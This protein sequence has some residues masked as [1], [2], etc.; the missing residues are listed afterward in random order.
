MSIQ[1]RKQRKMRYEAPLHKRRA[2]LRA[3]LGKELREKLKTDKRNALI[4]KGDKVKV[5]TGEKKNHMGKVLSVDYSELKIYVEGVLHKT[6]KGTEKPQ[7]VDPSNV[8]IIDGTFDKD[9]KLA[10]ERR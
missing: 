9:R 1:P 6:A 10:L 7:P 5:V 4:H 2:F 8:V 3:R